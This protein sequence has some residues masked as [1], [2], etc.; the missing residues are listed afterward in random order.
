[1][2][3]S[4]NDMWDLIQENQ[5]PTVFSCELLVGIFW[6]ETMFT[7]RRQLHGPAVGFGQVE[8]ATMKAVNDYYGTNYSESLI[9]IDDG[10]S[11]AITGDVLSMF[12]DK[13]LSPTGA[14]N[15][16]AGVKARP[17]NQKKVYQWLACE[18]ILKGGGTDD[19]DNVRKALMA[20]EPH[21]G[22]AVDSVL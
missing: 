19:S 3:L 16:Y 6:E 11:V 9:L 21:H 18:R 12:N 17:A 7:N 10:T 8:P 5:S 13:G 2:S 4:F 14:L 15:A 1:M 22:D 20:A